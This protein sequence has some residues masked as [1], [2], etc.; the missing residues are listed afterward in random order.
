MLSE[1][2]LIS[3]QL[4]SQESVENTQTV[5]YKLSYLRFKLRRFSYAPIFSVVA[6]RH[7]VGGGRAR[8][9]EG[10]RVLAAADE[11]HSE[12]NSAP[13]GTSSMLHFLLVFGH[14]ELFVR[15]NATI[16]LIC[17]TT[18]NKSITTTTRIHGAHTKTSVGASAIA[19]DD[20]EWEGSFRGRTRGNAVPIV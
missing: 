8:A 15:D 12:R 11:W 4:K 6:L 17:K 3:N 20:P 9:P 10:P 18:I 7:W 19:T 2:W 5:H 16:W 1:Y 14:W 13:L